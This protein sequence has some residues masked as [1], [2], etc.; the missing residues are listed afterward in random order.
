MKRKKTEWVAPKT[1]R[2]EFAMAALIGLLSHDCKDSGV[3]KLGDAEKRSY[4]IADGMLK[5]R[6]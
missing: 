2:D 6:K 4:E 1:L 3:W 5:A